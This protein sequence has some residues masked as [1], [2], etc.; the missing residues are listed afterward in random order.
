MH[1]TVIVMIGY[2]VV[3]ADIAVPLK[4]M[5]IVTCSFASSALV[6]DVLVRRTNVTRFLFGMKSLRGM[7]EPRRL[8][9]EGSE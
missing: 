2:Y 5:V 4:Y 8:T 6:Y 3:Q 9:A 1:Q 7:A